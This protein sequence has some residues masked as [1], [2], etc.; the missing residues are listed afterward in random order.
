VTHPT[1][2]LIPV[3]LGAAG[4]GAARSLGDAESVAQVIAVFATAG[5]FLVAIFVLG[6]A[7]GYF[8]RL[9]VTNR[10]LV[11]LQGYEVC[12]SWGLDDLPPSLLHY[13]APGSEG[14]SR[15]IDLDA[16]QN[17]LG[18]STEQFIEAKTILAFGKHL[19]RIKAQTPKRPRSAE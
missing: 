1:L 18:G 8:T 3:A 16:L 2:V 15:S 13:G 7:S 6:I 19:D 17:M 11:V 10:R 5:L 9:V 12:R 14:G 4:W